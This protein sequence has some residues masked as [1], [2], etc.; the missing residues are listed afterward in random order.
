MC[1]GILKNKKKDCSFQ[2]GKQELNI[3]LDIEYIIEKLRDIEIIKTVLFNKNQQ[4]IFNIISK[5]YN[6]NNPIIVKKIKISR[7]DENEKFELIELLK[8]L[9]NKHK[10]KEISE[11]DHKLGK[12]MLKLIQK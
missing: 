12:L 3:F 9:H 11:I 5:L 4:Q 7:L 2:I 10:L 1:L 6:K 8:Y